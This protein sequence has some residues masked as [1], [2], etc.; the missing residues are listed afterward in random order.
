MEPHWILSKDTSNIIW[1]VPLLGIREKWE[2]TF[3]YYE[4]HMDQREET[5]SRWGIS[6]IDDLER[7]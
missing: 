3:H 5:H 6:S 2:R 1:R 4:N 7:S